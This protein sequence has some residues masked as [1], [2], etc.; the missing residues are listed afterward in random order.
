M[1]RLYI[2]VHLHFK[3][4]YFIFMKKIITFLLCLLPLIVSQSCSNDDEFDTEIGTR[5]VAI[6]SLNATISHILIKSGDE[7]IFESSKLNT[8][9]YNQKVSNRKQI[10]IEVKANADTNEKASVHIG[11]VIGGDAIFI[12]YMSEIEHPSKGEELKV[13]GIVAFDE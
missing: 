2:I 10:Y 1:Q 8:T 11:E 6:S 13:S 9:Y 3:T 12:I 5:E 4:I 7:V